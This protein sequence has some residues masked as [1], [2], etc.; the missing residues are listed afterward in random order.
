MCGVGMTVSCCFG[1]PAQAAQSC[2]ASAFSFS[3][4]FCIID[5]C[6]SQMGIE[7]FYHVSSIELDIL[8]GAEEECSTV[9]SK[10]GKEVPHQPH[11]QLDIDGTGFGGQIFLNLSGV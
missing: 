4:F 5:L 10:P 3:T 6:F 9:V 1:L 11:T 2:N 8:G 7:I